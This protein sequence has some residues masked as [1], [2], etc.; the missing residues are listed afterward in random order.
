MSD[1]ATA[2]REAERSLDRWDS[3]PVTHRY[4]YE[5]AEVIRALRSLLAAT[6]PAPA[7]PEE[8]REAAERADEAMRDVFGGVDRFGDYCGHPVIPAKLAHA[9]QDLLVALAARGGSE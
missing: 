5:A 8:V 1:L 9:V 6:E 4:D 2:R 7:L 3:L